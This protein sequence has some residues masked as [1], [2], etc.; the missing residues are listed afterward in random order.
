[1]N[2]RDSRSGFA[3]ELRTILADALK[4]RYAVDGLVGSGGMALVF[5]GHDLEGDRAVAIKVLNP[6]IASAVTTARFVREIVWSSSLQHP[7]IVPV[8]D[9]GDARGFLYLVMPLIEGEPLSDR[10]ARQPPLPRST[11]IRYATQVALALEYAHHKGIV[12]RDIKPGNILISEDDAMVADFGVARALGIASGNTLT[13]PG[14]PIGTLAYMSPEQSLGSLEVD[15]RSDIY[16]LGCVVYE[17]LAGRRAFDGNSLG[18]ILKQQESLP[19][20]I[21]G[22]RADLPPVISAAVMQAL[23]KDPGLRQQTARAFADALAAGGLPTRDPVAAPRTGLWLLIAAG[24]AV[25]AL[26]ATLLLGR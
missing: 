7:N 14:A 24:L 22:L 10:L 9:S 16:S 12:H 18:Q 6:E 17:M 5:A 19:P 13:G 21:D 3:R 11:A 20:S 26:V 15:G 4:D 8:L 2:R 1:M 23:Q 25:A